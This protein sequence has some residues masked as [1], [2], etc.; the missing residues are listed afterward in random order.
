[1][2]P[3]PS[4]LATLITVFTAIILIIPITDYDVKVVWELIHDSG[5]SNSLD[6]QQQLANLLSN[7]SPL[8]LLSSLVTSSQD[9]YINIGSK[10]CKL[11][12]SLNGPLDFIPVSDRSRQVSLYSFKAGVID[13][14]IAG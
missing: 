3:T 8:S 12:T 7:T 4:L 6:K 1:M 13:T 2:S 10:F 14:L 11:I 9:S 5:G